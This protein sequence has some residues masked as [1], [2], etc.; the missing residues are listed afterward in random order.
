[1]VA[2]T[3]SIAKAAQDLRTVLEQLHLGETV[4]LVRDGG[5]PEALLVSLRSRRAEG[6]AMADWD[7]GWD[8]LTHNISRAWESEKGA[9]EILTH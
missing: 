2:T 5:A 1:M 8:E 3:L 7:E 4:T 6:G 9:I